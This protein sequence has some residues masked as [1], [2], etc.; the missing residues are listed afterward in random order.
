VY[1]ANVVA[2]T[3]SLNAVFAFAIATKGHL[4]I[5]PAFGNVKQHL[6]TILLWS[7][8]IGFALSFATVVVD[9]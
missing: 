7:Y 4:E 2:A 3:F 6:C 1:V 8:A 5:R 9:R